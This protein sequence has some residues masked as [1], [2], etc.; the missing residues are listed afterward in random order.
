MAIMAQNPDDTQAQMMGSYGMAVPLPASIMPPVDPHASLT[1]PISAAP[2]EL[3]PMMAASGS[4]E[5]KPAKMSALQPQEEHISKNLMADYQKDA[6]P[7]GSDD[8]H[9]GFLGKFLHGLNV[10]TGGVNR[11]GIEERGLESRIQNIDKQESDEGL[12]GAETAGREESTQEAPQKA[13]DAHLQSGATTR[14]ENDRAQG[15][16]DAP[17]PP[18]PSLATAYAHAVNQALKDN[19]DPSQDPIVQ[20]LSDAITSLQKQPAAPK[21]DYQTTIGPDGKPHVYGLDATGKKVADE[22]IHYERPDAAPSNAGTWSL[23]NGADGNPILFNS[24]TGKTEN[25]P[26]NLARK[27]N[28]EE[29]KRADLATNV[30]ENLDKLEDIASRRPD[31]FGP[32]AG[33]MTKMREAVGT[34]DPDVATLKTLEDN[35]GMAMQSAHGMRSAQH[36]ETSAQSVLNGFKNSPQA[37][38]AAIKA[39][40]ASVGTFQNNVKDTNDAGKPQA[41]SS[42]VPSG[43]DNEVYVGGKLVGH[44]VGGRYVALGK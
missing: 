5:G 41:E 15:M 25:A 22:G 18:E 2:P 19:R 9:P 39:A 28:A 34:D 33:R 23:Q 13:A 29:Q 20:H 4:A 27:P 36:V 17:A 42:V 40:R 10:S 31:L 37:L 7:Y 6:N 11:R 30:N 1:A 16:E 12:Q 26:G 43:A 35:L 21:M 32:V 24:K 8:N 14:E 38:K 3:P 44:T